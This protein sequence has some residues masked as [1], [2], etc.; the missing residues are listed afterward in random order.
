MVIQMILVT[1]S[2][3]LICSVVCDV[4]AFIVCNVGS[5]TDDFTNWRLIPL[6]NI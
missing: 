2:D 5:V 3:H 6:F 1:D 4:V